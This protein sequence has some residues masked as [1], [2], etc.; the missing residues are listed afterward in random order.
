MLHSQLR[1][2][3]KSLPPTFLVV[4]KLPEFLCH[5]TFINLFES[6]TTRCMV[7]P[8]INANVPDGIFKCLELNIFLS[9]S[10]KMELYFKTWECYYNPHPNCHYNLTRKPWKALIYKMPFSYAG[11]GFITSVLEV[12]NISWSHWKNINALGIFDNLNCCLKI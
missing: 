3:Y 6:N 7:S 2:L 1:A 10:E 11:V 4:R 5:Y 12:G 8:F 9:I